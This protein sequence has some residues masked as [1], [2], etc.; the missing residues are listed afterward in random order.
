MGGGYLYVVGEAHYGGG[1][2]GGGTWARGLDDA[3][4]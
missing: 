1:G 4:N 3:P 2:G